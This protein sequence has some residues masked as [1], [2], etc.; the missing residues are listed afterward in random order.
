MKMAIALVVLFGFLAGQCVRAE[1]SKIP[2]PQWR[3]VVTI[4][5]RT[6]GRQLD[7]RKLTDRALVFHDPGTCN[8]IIARIRPVGDSH[9]SAV[10]TCR[11][12]GSTEADL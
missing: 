3:I 11:Q 7:Q 6:T 5:D 8:S 12:V 2:R 4:I 9:T 10:L 1:E